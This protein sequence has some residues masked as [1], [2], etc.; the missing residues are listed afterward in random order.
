MHVESST[1][2]LDFP[3]TKRS[4]QVEWASSIFEDAVFP[5]ERLRKRA[6]AFLVDKAQ[7][8]ARS[9]TGSCRDHAAAKGAYRLL[10]NDRLEASHFWD[11]YHHFSAEVVSEF[12][13]IYIAHDTTCLSFPTLKKT[14][15]LGTAVSKDA[16]YLWMHSGLAMRRNGE[17][18]G[19]LHANVWARPPED[20]GRREDAHSRPIEEKESYEWIRGI[21]AVA[22]LQSEHFAGTRPIH[23][24]DIG[25]DIHEVYE[26]LQKWNHGCI[27]RCG[28]NRGVE[29]ECVYL[30]DTVRAQP[31]L[32]TREIEVPR[33]EGEPARVA[34][35]EVRA[36]RVTIRP[37]DKKDKR[38]QP[39]EV[40][41]VMVWEPNPPAGVK[42][43]EWYLCTTESIATVAAC[44]AVVEGYKLRWRI[45]DFHLVLKS[46][47]H[48]EK[49]QLKTA[50]RIT[51]LVGFLAPVAIRI[52]QLRD[53]ARTEPDAPCTVI[54]DEDEWK[55]LW[56]YVHEQRVPRDLP[57]PTLEDAVKMIG[58][59]GGHLGRKGDGM[60]G[61]RSLWEGMYDLE[62]L[63][64]GSRLTV[65]NH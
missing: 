4:R 64:I 8:P 62:L 14:T 44:W 48:A 51:K 10:S 56:S 1:S 47:C 18:L 19:L 50:E 15:E 22:G 11:P 36:V 9:V 13:S 60:P 38:R 34:R 12:T 39:F 52:L 65:L 2:Q 28:Y 3:A 26:A 54:L 29:G 57:T 63:L 33:H 16:Q 30:K 25:G 27:I 5:D 35:V 53:K 61:V 7:H 42:R 41:V 17:A 43:L 23:L 6:I 45:E 55:L 46:G 31:V 37:S 49:T 24:M 58:R 59:L 21:N 40:N 32:D 20:F